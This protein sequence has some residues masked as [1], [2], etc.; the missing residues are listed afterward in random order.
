M[1]K[2]KLCAAHALSSWGDNLW[3]FSGGILFLAMDQPSSL[4]LI[5]V[6]GLALSSAVILFGAVL[7]EA[8]DQT[9]SRWNSAKYCL[10]L[11]NVSVSASAGVIGLSLAGVIP[12]NV[13]TIILAITCSAS[14]RLASEGLL[15][16]LHKDWLV[17]IA[18]NDAEY[19]AD[20]NAKLR[21]ISLA[22]KLL[23]PVVAGPFFTFAGYVW[24][25]LIVAAWNGG[26]LFAEYSLL[27]NIY[28][29]CERLQKVK[30]D[31]SQ[32][33]AE[34]DLMSEEEEEEEEEPNHEGENKQLYPLK[35]IEAYFASWKT[36]FGHEIKFAG[37]ALS[38][39]YMTVLSLG[40]VT[41][42]YILTQGVSEMILGCLVTISAAF[43]IVG[44]VSYPKLRLKF[45]PLIT[46][47]LG[48]SL[49]VFP[50]ATSTLAM[51][52][53][54]GL[55]WA[56]LPG[57]VS[58]RFG[59]WVADLTVSQILQEK[60]EE[61]RRG[62]I[63]GIQ[64]S[65]NCGFDLLKCVLVIILPD[66]AQFHYLVTTSFVFISAAWIFFGLYSKGQRR[67]VRETNTTVND[68]E[69]NISS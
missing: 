28:N 19:L 29:S 5:A 45:G 20:M 59:L 39:T 11:Q 41:C 54:P 23:A 9:K 1:S 37:L 8:I 15:I 50:A 63:N 31:N 42:A 51:W 21:T 3:L 56:F 17:V 44:S 16:V 62:V 61:D 32:P 25:S 30:G 4:R 68:S 57:I 58:A 47:N 43:G 48:L 35:I 36:Y 60:V 27:R 14:A 55:I 53:F 13:W 52:A 34:R 46:G 12:L 18:D 24:S 10:I 64:S 6:Y 49:L 40:N 7:G 33:N 22:A 67:N 38:L 65:L 69:I 2:V 66:P 26:S